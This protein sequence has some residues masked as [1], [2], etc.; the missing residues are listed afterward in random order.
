MNQKL[1]NSNYIN[2]IVRYHALYYK[3]RSFCLIYLHLTFHI[4][5]WDVLHFW[6]FGFNG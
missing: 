6:A 3:N 1:L 2:P 5:Y 4:S